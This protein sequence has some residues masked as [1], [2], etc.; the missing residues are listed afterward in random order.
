MNK[1]P[2]LSVYPLLTETIQDGL[3][4]TRSGENV[5]IEHSYEDKRF[6]L[7]LTPELREVLFFKAERDHLQDLILRGLRITGGD[8][9]KYSRGIPAKFLL[10]GYEDN[11]T[12]AEKIKNLRNSKGR[13]T[14]G[15]QQLIL[16]TEDFESPSQ[17]CL[18]NW[19]S[20]MLPEGLD[21]EKKGSSIY[22]DSEFITEL[23]VNG[24]KVT[25]IEKNAEEM[26]QNF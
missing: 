18:G 5:L 19:I 1:D 7:H 8:D 3:N 24:F 12:P 23:V 22:T 6:L 15:I 16:L 26:T 9:F 21:I 4:R 14:E 25:D 13:I 17:L 20:I 10:Y 11:R 2:L